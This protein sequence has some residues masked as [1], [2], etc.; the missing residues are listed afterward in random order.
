MLAISSLFLSLAVLAASEDI[1]EPA[2]VDE[3]LLIPVL[4]Y[5]PPVHKRATR[6]MPFSGG[7]T[8]SML[9]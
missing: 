5:E 4:E 6:V 9:L 3:I 7:K 2:E 1:T 8:T